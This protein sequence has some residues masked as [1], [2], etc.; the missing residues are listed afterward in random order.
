[1]TTEIIMLG[2]GTPIIDP[3]KEGAAVAIRYMNQKNDDYI[4]FD[5]GR[6]VV[7][8]ISQAKI[9]PEKITT[10][11]LTHLHSDH[12]TGLPDLIFTFGV[13]GRQV[14]LMIYGP[15]GTTEMVNHLM[16]AYQMDL[17]IRKNGLE[18]TNNNAYNIQAYD[19]QSEQSFTLNYFIVKPFPVKHGTWEC[20]GYRITTPEEVI[21]VSGDTAPCES[22]I[23]NSS[24]CTILIHEVYSHTGLKTREEQWQKYHTNMHT[25]SLELGEIAK[26]ISPKKLILYHQLLM[27]H[28]VH[29]IIREIKLNYS[30]EI[31]SAQD[32][33]RY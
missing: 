22:L 20:F 32:L 25:S 2:T 31:I 10:L 6:G 26:I 19:I 14:P 33:D 1:M 12:T 17:K 18:P 16:L 30:G 3:N 5:S 15:K 28:S 21:I 7:R 9:P 29:D 13:E 24:D 27:Q 11:F 4:I 8:R 23:Q